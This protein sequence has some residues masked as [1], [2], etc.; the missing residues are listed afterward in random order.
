VYFCNKWLLV[1]D[2]DPLVLD[3]FFSFDADAGNLAPDVEDLEKLEAAG[4]TIV[5]S[6]NVSGAR[7]EVPRDSLYR[8]TGPTVNH[9]RSVPV[10]DRFDLW[11]DIGYLPQA[12]E[13]IQRRAVELGGHIEDT[14][15]GYPGGLP[16][17]F[18]VLPDAAI[19][20]LRQEFPEELKWAE[21]ETYGCLAGP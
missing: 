8:V 9:V 2:G 1:P 4:A 16:S 15:P 14:R 17:F 6:F 7:A 12:E 10:A 5:H 11:M 18:G 3:F 20:Q 13:G 19:K 21:H